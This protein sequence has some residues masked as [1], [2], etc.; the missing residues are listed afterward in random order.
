[1]VLPDVPRLRTRS[2]KGCNLT[3]ASKHADFRLRL[4]IFGRELIF[5]AVGLVNGDAV[6]DDSSRQNT[7]FT[8]ARTPP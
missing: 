8:E 3:P 6:R 5:S 7:R 1:M 4:P 2:P